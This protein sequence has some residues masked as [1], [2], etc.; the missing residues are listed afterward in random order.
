[1]GINIFT[2]VFFPEK[3]RQGDRHVTLAYIIYIGP[4][5]CAPGGHRPVSMFIAHYNG[6]MPHEVAVRALGAT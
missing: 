3:R 6:L 4:D 5:P 1:M 2:F